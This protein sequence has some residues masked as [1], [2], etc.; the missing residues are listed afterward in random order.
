MSLA[1]EKLSKDSLRTKIIRNATRTRSSVDI[2]VGGQDQKKLKQMRQQIKM[3][4]KIINI[5][6]NQ[7]VF[8]SFMGIELHLLFLVDYQYIIIANN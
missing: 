4:S 7:L 2:C 3:Q 8:F 6:T 1:I 5:L